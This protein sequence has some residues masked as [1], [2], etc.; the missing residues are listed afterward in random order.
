MYVTRYAWE[1][2][3]AL[4]SVVVATPVNNLSGLGVQN[5]RPWEISWASGGVFSDTSL[6]LAVYGF[7]P[8][9]TNQKLTTHTLPPSLWYPVTSALEALPGRQRTSPVLDLCF[10]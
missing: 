10:P 9:S 3:G 4:V 6:L 5:P 1:M 8:P 7:I 2:G